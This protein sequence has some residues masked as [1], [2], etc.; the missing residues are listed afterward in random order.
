[1][2]H[3]NTK[4]LEKDTSVQNSFWC[5]EEG[6]SGHI[7][8]FG[9]SFDKSAQE[10]AG[11]LWHLYTSVIFSSWIISLVWN[12]WFAS[13]ST[14]TSSFSYSG[15]VYPE[16]HSRHSFLP[17]LSR[18]ILLVCLSEESKHSKS[19]LSNIM[20]NRHMQLFPLL[21][22]IKLRSTQFLWPHQAHFNS[23][24]PTRG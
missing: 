13:Q 9:N 3:V 20:V 19:L 16:F 7:H 1:M 6:D 10:S 5:V 24:T 15:T 8:P 22:N 18:S 17:P 11:K 12:L 2:C 14:E 4:K 21:V 23:W